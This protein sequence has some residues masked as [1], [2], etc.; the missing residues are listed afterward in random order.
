MHA[1]SAASERNRSVWGQINTKYRN[2]LS[3]DNKII[4]IRGTSNIL[5]EPD[6]QGHDKYSL[7]TLEYISLRTIVACMLCHTL[8]HY[9]VD[10]LK[11]S[12]S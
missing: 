10:F 12:D 8:C 2:K 1:T 11:S 6:E 5:V 9:G 7:T 4:F 3:L